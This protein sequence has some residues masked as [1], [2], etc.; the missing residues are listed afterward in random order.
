M[1]KQNYLCWNPLKESRPVFVDIESYN[2]IQYALGHDISVVIFDKKT[3][4][5]ILIKCYLSKLIFENSELEHNVYFKDKLPIYWDNIEKDNKAKTNKYEL[6]DNEN[7]CLHL[8]DMID[9]LKIKVI[10]GY[11]ICFDYDSINRLY[12]CVNK[13]IALKRKQYRNFGIKY[14]NIPHRIHNGFQKINVF[15]LYCAITL[16]LEDNEEDRLEY[17]AFCVSNHFYSDSLKCI[18]SGEEFV[19]RCFIDFD[20]IEQHMGIE[21]C[22]DEH[23]LW[24]WYLQKIKKHKVKRIP[25]LNQKNSKSCYTKNGIYNCYRV[26]RELEKAQDKGRFTEVDLTELK[27]IV[28]TH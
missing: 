21:D 18:A 22:L 19:T 13:N 16:Y 8:N 26:L 24:L 10:I 3:K 4:A 5:P 6:L 14:K 23:N 7:I 28:A 17:Y 11:N 27:S 20:I 1:S 25:R 12:S 15:D 2:Q 9:D